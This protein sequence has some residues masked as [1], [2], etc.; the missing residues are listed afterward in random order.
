MAGVANVLAG[1]AV[2]AGIVVGAWFV[3]QPLTQIADQ[4]RKI[5][6]K[7]TAEKQIKADVAVWRAD[8]QARA[9]TLP[10][11]Y[12]K[13]ATANDALRAWLAELRVDPQQLAIKPVVVQPQYATT[14]SGATT[15]TV[16]GYVL[17]QPVQLAGKS[18][19]EVVAVDYGLTR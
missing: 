17:S 1:V 11:A 14:A 3:A 12:E 19:G 6:V 13:L 8:V 10:A 9:A 2:G 5:A 15:S 4:Q 18:V 16:V 7:G